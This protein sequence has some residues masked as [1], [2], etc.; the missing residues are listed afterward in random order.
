MVTDWIIWALTTV[1]S[2]S[3]KGRNPNQNNRLRNTESMG[4]TTGLCYWARAMAEVLWPWRWLELET[5]GLGPLFSPSMSLDSGPWHDCRHLQA[6]LPTALGS[7]RKDELPVSCSG[8]NRME[9]LWLAQVGSCV[10][11]W[12]W[13]G[14]WDA[15]TGEILSHMFKPAVRGGGGTERVCWTGKLAQLSWVF[16]CS[17]QRHCAISSSLVFA[18]WTDTNIPTRT[19]VKKN[20][21]LPRCP[22][23]FIQPVCV[24][25][26]ACTQVCKC[27]RCELVPWAVRDLR[28]VN[29]YNLSKGNSCQTTGL[30]SRDQLL[31]LLYDL[32]Q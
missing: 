20:V 31:T 7:K 29:I 8:K 14:E 4:G 17:W 21:E 6:Y 10:F 9:A 32:L 5:Q 25:A 1:L 23:L 15:M 18:C 11:P 27:V 16:V 3:Y 24:N 26:R 19:V 30:F 12:L 13:S 2:F 22:W 28:L